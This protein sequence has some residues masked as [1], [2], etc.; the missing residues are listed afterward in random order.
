M[1]PTIQALNKNKPPANKSTLIN[2][3]KPRPLVQSSLE[4]DRSLPPQKD[5]TAEFV[6]ALT[7]PPATDQ[8]A[9]LLLGHR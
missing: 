4:P 6:L 5:G 2:S 8:T 1:R 9:P 3:D 7:N